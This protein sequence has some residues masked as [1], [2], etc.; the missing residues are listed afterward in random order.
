MHCYCT[1]MLMGPD[2]SMDSAEIKF[3]DVTPKSDKLLCNDW[4]IGFAA[5]KSIY[6]GQAWILSFVNAL[7]QATFTFLV[8]FQKRYT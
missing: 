8:I 3:D 6:A 5:Q 4:A 1:N 7:V 2:V